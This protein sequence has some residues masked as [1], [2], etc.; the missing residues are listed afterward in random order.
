MTEEWVIPPQAAYTATCVTAGCENENIRIPITAAAESP[1][2]Q[3]GPC[4]QMITNITPA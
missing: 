4:G 1:N 3:C 2:V